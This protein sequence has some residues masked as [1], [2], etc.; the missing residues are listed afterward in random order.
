MA[1]TTMPAYQPI[2]VAGMLG[3]VALNQDIVTRTVSQ[4]V[5]QV[6]TIT[7]ADFTDNTDYTVTINGIPVT[8][9]SGAGSSVA[10]IRT[11]LLAALN[12]DVNVARYVTFAAGG[13][14]VIVVT[15]ITAGQSFTIVTDDESTGDMSVALTTAASTGTI[16]FGKGVA[17]NGFGYVKQPTSSGDVMEGISVFVQ[18]ATPNGVPDST[19]ADDGVAT[20]T[21][22]EEMS[23][24]RKGRIWVIA[25]TAITTSSGVF[26]RHA[27]SGAFTLGSLTA[28]DDGN[29][30]A[31]PSSRWISGAAQAGQLCEVEINLP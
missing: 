18:K 14:G 31:L 26:V 12:A 10:S 23:V 5:A 9:D 29:T 21:D 6:S 1:Q 7:I 16:G 2:A 19:L 28:T 4:S 11:A 25:E 27:V 15:G 24:L 20:Y 17:L 22:G 3:D 8:I 13:A 30:V